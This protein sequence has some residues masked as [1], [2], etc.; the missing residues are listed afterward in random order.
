MVLK[1]DCPLIR[2]VRLGPET[3]RRDN[4]IMRRPTAVSAED[5]TE[6]ANLYAYYNHCSDDGD[7]DGYASCFAARGELV[8]PGIEI[9]V[10]G[11]EALRA[12]KVDDASRRGGRIRRHWN[13]GLALAKVDDQAVEGRCYLHG[14][15]G[16]PG[17]PP[18]LAD[19]G[20][21]EDRLIRE[22]GQWCFARRV[23]YMDYS[24][25]TRP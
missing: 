15:N 7:A 14:Y 21:Y 24:E 25:F 17:Q 1:R 8:I 10:V 19:I 5:Y 2:N 20:R 12:F 23:I 18:V 4:V 3:S 6:I 11:R 9:R 22:G 13:S 16:V